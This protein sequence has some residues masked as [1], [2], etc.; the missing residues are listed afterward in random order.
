[1]KEGKPYWL[2]KNDDIAIISDK[3]IKYTKDQIRQNNLDY[4]WYYTKKI[5]P[6]ILSVIL[7]PILIAV[8]F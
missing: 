1:M 6:W 2:H 7:I 8:I 5:G 3:E 4:I